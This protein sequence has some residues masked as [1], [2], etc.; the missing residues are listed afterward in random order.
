VDVDVGGVW[1]EG[2]GC[3][4]KKMGGFGDGKVFDIASWLRVWL[5]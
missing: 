5:G 1:R 4:K 3:G 2:W